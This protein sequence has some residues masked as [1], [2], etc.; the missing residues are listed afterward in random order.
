[1]RMSFNSKSDQELV[2][3]DQGG[4]AGASNST[5]DP[6]SRAK[7]VFADYDESEPEMRRKVSAIGSLL[8]L[9]HDILF[10]YGMFTEELV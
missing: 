2:S 8:T 9:P 10:M 5:D 4:H 6:N 1:M 3:G 7:Q